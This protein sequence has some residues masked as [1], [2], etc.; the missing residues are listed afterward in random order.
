MIK[1]RRMTT[2]LSYDNATTATTNID[3]SGR[4]VV[5]LVPPKSITI[6]LT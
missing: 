6:S 4:N 5:P 3:Y 1:E 2:P